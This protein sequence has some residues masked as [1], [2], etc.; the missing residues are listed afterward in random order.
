MV[1]FFYLLSNFMFVENSSIMNST[2]PN[3]KRQ[4]ITFFTLT[5]GLSWS[6]FFIGQKT[7]IVFIILLGVWSPSLTSLFLTGYFYRKKGL[8]Q[9][10]GRLKRYKIKWYWW[11]LLLLLPA[12]IH[13]TGRSLWQFL[14]V[15]EISPAI[16]NISYWLSAIIPSF[17]IAGFGEE[18]GW[19]G[20][21][22][23]RL[24]R[25]YSPIM[26]AFILAT[27][28]LCWHL[29]TYWLGQGIHNVPFVYLLA[30]IYPWT[31]IFNWLYNKSGGSLIFAI[32]FHAISNASLSIVRFF[33]N[34]DE[35]PIS[36][37]LITNFSFPMEKGG[38]YLLVCFVYIL[39]AAIVVIKG[40]FKQ[41]NT[42][43]P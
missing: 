43:I 29:P 1:G 27:V 24:Q 33:P 8:L 25:H 31:F 19:R 16:L 9:L 28:H 10:L 13:F 7:D 21:A 37:E 34:D 17:L 15:G 39:V 38:P 20:F 5:Y 35:V 6:L 26:S 32:G 12:S 36:P 30:F 2:T 22:L 11:V 40:N 41:T 4:L 14:Y 18:L 42:D 3:T 23:P